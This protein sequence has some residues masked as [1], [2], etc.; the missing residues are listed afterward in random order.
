MYGAQVGN[1]WH[2]ARR[3]N[4]FLKWLIVNNENT[5]N[6]SIQLDMSSTL[7][8]AETFRSGS[9]WCLGSRPVESDGEVGKDGG[10][11]RGG[12]PVPGGSK[13]EQELELA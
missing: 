10:G 12:S 6:L 5:V 4:V 13:C 7:A 8:Q 1:S 3:C 11:R 2:C 9:G